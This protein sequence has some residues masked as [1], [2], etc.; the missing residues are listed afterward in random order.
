MD[1]PEQFW[2]A[3]IVAAFLVGGGKG[4]LPMVAMLSV[5][6]MSLV[7]SPMLGAALLLPVYLISDVY[8][9]FIYR[10]SFSPR[11]LATVF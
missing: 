11:N 3:A 2:A 1:S 4:G 7:M 8:G 10:R 6:I 9:I 5:P